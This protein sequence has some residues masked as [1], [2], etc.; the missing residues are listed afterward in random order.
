[1]QD[2]PHVQRANS[3]DSGVLQLYTHLPK[4]NARHGVAGHQLMIET[5][6]LFYSLCSAPQDNAIEFEGYA[7]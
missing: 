5:V 1:M 7:S 3:G 6:T 4:D 2:M